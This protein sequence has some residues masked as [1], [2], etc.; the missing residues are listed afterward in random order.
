MLAVFLAWLSHSLWRGGDREA[1]EGMA[2]WAAAVAVAGLLAV[3]VGLAGRQAC[4][5]EAEAA[6]AVREVAERAVDAACSTGKAVSE[7]R[8]L[9]ALATVGWARWTEAEAAG[10]ADRW[11]LA[12]VV[13]GLL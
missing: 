1:S 5:T 13:G 2:R 4:T 3:A 8:C 6:A 9:A 12:V 7:A 11:V 10:A